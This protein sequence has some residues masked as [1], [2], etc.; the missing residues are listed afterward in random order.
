LG[1]GKSSYIYLPWN[2]IVMG[3]NALD[4]YILPSV[5][6]PI[7]VLFNTYR[8]IKISPKEDKIYTRRPDSDGG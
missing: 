7:Q 3:L 6:F 1:G 2:S 8:N 4:L 5:R